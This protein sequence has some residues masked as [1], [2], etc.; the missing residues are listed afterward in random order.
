M[1]IKIIEPECER[2]VVIENS[3]SA[4]CIPK[5][6][7]GIYKIY[8]EKY[9]LLYIGKSKNLHERVRNHLRGS[10]CVSK[11][12]AHHFRYFT[13]F[14]ENDPVS[15]EL[16]ETHLIN[17]LKPLFNWDKVYTYESQ[18]YNPIYNPNESIRRQKAEEYLE[19]D[20]LKFSL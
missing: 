20:L 2:L 5:K 15:R 9:Q 4:I 12:V 19:E 7:G 16:Y 13:Y 8:G 1:T 14:I 11:D 10:D 17:T 6:C 18:K 3:D